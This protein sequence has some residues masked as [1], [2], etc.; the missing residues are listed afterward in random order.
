MAY[1]KS[2]ASGVL[3]AAASGKLNT[4]LSIRGDIPSSSNSMLL[5][6]S[7]TQQS[8]FAMVHL[9]SSD[10][11][12]L[13]LSQP[14][15]SEAVIAGTI[16]SS[17]LRASRRL[18]ED[19]RVHGITD[20][21]STALASMAG[22][23]PAFMLS[24]SRLHI[25]WR[26]GIPPHLRCIVWPLSAG[27]ALRVTPA[28]FSMAQTRVKEVLHL[29]KKKKE[30]ENRRSTSSIS[31]PSSP[32]PR[33]LSSSSPKHQQQQQQQL[34][35]SSSSPNKA[36]TPV[37]KPGGLFHGSKLADIVK[38]MKTKGKNG[39]QHDRHNLAG[40]DETHSVHSDLVGRE[41]SIDLIELDLL[42]TFPH[43]HLFGPSTRAKKEV[44]GE[45]KDHDIAS[46]TSSSS[47][48]AGGESA[49]T[50]ADD[51]DSDS[52]GPLHA[53]V[54]S[55]LRAFAVFR[56]EIGYVQGMSYIAA[57]TALHI[58]GTAVWACVAPDRV[59]LQLQ[60]M[61]SSPLQVLLPSTPSV[62]YRQFHLHHQR[63]NRILPLQLQVLLPIH[64]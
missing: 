16:R 61:R 63:R 25:L 57:M 46:G 41:A 29:L 31:P 64:H 36:S 7:S 52:E 8:N 45:D 54:L 37:A 35:S 1:G 50:M 39:K 40:S 34:A 17:E 48:A 38:T 3:S 32:R 21:W 62:H 12:T 56:P 19:M 14:P 28:V 15:L 58:A 18:V 59:T 27:N 6:Q 33:E 13:S 30:E 23:W 49:T 4:S 60:Q 20:E 10:G 9:Q 44:L 51:D 11:K 22:S 5:R 55:V 2:N 42:R 47:A 26:K 53:T 43:L 24:D